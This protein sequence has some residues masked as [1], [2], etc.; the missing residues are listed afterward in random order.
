MALKKEGLERVGLR[1]PEDV[2]EWYMKESNAL[3]LTMSQYMS[4]VLVTHKRNQ[5]SAE[6][7]RNVSEMS[8]DP[9]VMNL[10]REMLELMKSPEIM[11]ALKEYQEQVQEKSLQ[12][13]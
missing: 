1:V 6:A 13:P 7:I 4:F 11:L 5:E 9:E 2:K 8:K 3:G 10:N 12:L